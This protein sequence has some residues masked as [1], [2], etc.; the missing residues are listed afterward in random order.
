[1]SQTS[2][3]IDTE[4]SLTSSKLRSATTLRPSAKPIEQA[5]SAQV[6]TRLHVCPSGLNQTSAIALHSTCWTNSTAK[7]ASPIRVVMTLGIANSVGTTDSVHVDPSSPDNQTDVV[8]TPL[9]EPVSFQ[10]APTMM[11]SLSVDVR[12][13]LTDPVSSGE[14]DDQFTPSPDT[15]TRPRSRSDEYVNTSFVASKVTLSP[16]PVSNG[17]GAVLKI[18]PSV[19]MMIVLRDSVI[20]IET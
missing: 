12:R 3:W 6:S 20:K 8:L 15:A 7:P 5:T 18:P 16:T 14:L 17:N 4:E 10:V 13:L 1:M 19:P 2:A 9:P 11:T